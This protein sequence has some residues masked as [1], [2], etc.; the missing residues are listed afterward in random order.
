MTPMWQVLSASYIFIFYNE[1]TYFDSW[2]KQ[3][4]YTKF[5]ILRCVGKLV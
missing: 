5:S 4:I 3:P 1:N 2:T